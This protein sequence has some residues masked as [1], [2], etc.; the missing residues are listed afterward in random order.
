[1]RSRRRRVAPGAAAEGSADVDPSF[2]PVPDY[3]QVNRIRPSGGLKGIFQQFTRP[4]DP[5]EE[6]EL[7]QGTVDAVEMNA[8]YRGVF[9]TIAV[10]GGL[11]MA[12]SF[13][14]VG[15]LPDVEANNKIMWEDD[16]VE[17]IQNFYGAAMGTTVC[18]SALA[19]LMG[20]F[21]SIILAQMDAKMTVE[22]FEHAGVRCQAVFPVTVITLI[23]FAVATLSKMSLVYPAWVMYTTVAMLAVI[24]VFF[25]LV[26]NSL[27]NLKLEMGRI[28]F[29]RKYG[30]SGTNHKT[31]GVC[32]GLT[33]FCKEQQQATA[34][35]GAGAA[36]PPGPPS[37]GPEQ[38]VREQGRK[39]D[40]VALWS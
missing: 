8:N 27:N 2:K 7:M 23:A 21:F 10:I 17:A 30:V 34:P 4:F 15:A 39:V 6:M 12:F 29:E 26:V 19:M 3:I 28:S 20:V 14:A 31:P 18:F 32:D 36:A 38:P 9:D 16:Q 5:V 24:V 1:M 22:F 33:W 40:E 13:D 11:V 37:G 35:A 25:L